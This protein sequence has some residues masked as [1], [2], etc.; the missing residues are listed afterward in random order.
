MT[1]GEKKDGHDPWVRRTIFAAA[2]QVAA[3]GISGLIGWLFSSKG[4]AW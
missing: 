4:G 3:S 1:A 2:M